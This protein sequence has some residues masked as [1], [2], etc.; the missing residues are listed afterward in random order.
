MIERTD[1][2]GTAAPRVVLVDD[3]T[4]LRQG[5]R[6]ALQEHGIDVIG[7]ASNGRAGAQLVL[8]L[9]PDVTI[10]DLHM[11]LLDGIG[12]LRAI[13]DR[14]PGARVL[15]FTI[16]TDADEVVEAL[17]AGAAG[18][19]LK[20]SPP[21]EVVAAVRAVIDGDSVISPR[22]AGRLVERLRTS[23][24]DSASTPRTPLTPR[25]LEILRLIA[26]GRENHQIA[27]ALF[28]SPSTA[29]NHVAS[30]LEKLGVETRVQAAVYAVRE[31]VV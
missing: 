11:P 30:V 29:K 31:G 5:L 7:E 13:V 19:V 28:I 26:E 17:T 16:S 4:L 27:E 2:P 10:M 25:E 1:I 24:R 20:S 15:M 9:R 3:H 18:Y 21:H 23:P 6:Q 8:E 22:V 12:A 14:D